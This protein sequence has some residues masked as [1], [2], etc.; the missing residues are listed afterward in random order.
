M[1]SRFLIGID[2]G[3]T[4]SVV[5][6]L[7]TQ[8][9]ATQSD[10][11]QSDAASAISVMDV[12][13]LIAHG[14]VRTLPAL[15]SFL[16]F[17]TPDELSSGAVSATWDE[18][19]PMVTGLLAREQGA[20]VPARQVSSAKSW[21]SHPGVNRRA[22]ILPAQAEP[23]QPMISP[24]EASARYLMHLRDAWNGALGTT[25][26]T[27]FEQQEIVLTVP[28]S[29]DEEA[30]ELTVEAARIAG[31]A[32]LTL[33]EEPLAAFYAWME[34]SGGPWK[35]SGGPFKPSVGLSGEG[36]IGSPAKPDVG[37]A[38]D[39]LRD[40]ELILICD[41]GG[42]T[43]DFSLIRATLVDGEPQF[44]RTA[45]GDHILLGGDNLDLALAHLVE[46]KLTDAKLT[47]R[48]R[49]AL[50][51][52]CCAAK[53][54]LLSDA[55][56][57][58][59]PVIILGSGRAVIG[60][61]LAVDLTREKVLQIL[62]TGFLPIT[63]PDAMPSRARPTALREL[64]L[65]YAAD[66]A[67]TR[68]LAAFLTQAAIAMNTGQRMVRP[69]AVLFNGGFCTPSFTRDRIATAI[70]NWFG[71]P[72][73]QWRPKLLDNDA[74]ESAVARGAACYGRVRR[75]TG[76]RVKV[77]SARAYYIGLPAEAADSAPQGIC[78]LPAGSEAGTTLPPLARE[79]T[80]LANR[81]VSFT[82]YSSRTRHDAH[83]GL[84]TL[85]EA[86]FHRHAPLTSLLRYGK[87]MRELYLKVRLRAGFTEVGTLE[88][89]CESPETGHRWRLQFELRGEDPEAQQSAQQASTHGAVTH[90]AFATSFA[91]D[92]AAQ[93]IRTVFASSAELDAPAPET[94][95]SQLEAALGAKR[96]HWP[97]AVVRGLADVLLE[98]APGRKHSPRHEL[99]WLN[100]LGF[101]LRPGF[102]FPGDDARIHQLWAVA[103]AAPVFAGDL[104]CQVEML[105]MLRRI[106]GGINASRQQALYREHT[107]AADSKKKKPR[108]N[109]QL[110]YE[111]WRLLASL[112]HL[113]ARH[114]A[115][116]GRELL[117]KIK[118]DPEDAIWLWSL[119]RLG[120][121]IPLYGPLPCVVTPEIAAEWLNVLLDLP[122]CTAAT[123]SAIAAI[124]QRTDDSSRDIDDAIRAQA[125]SRLTEFGIAQ[126]VI[127]TVSHYVPPQRADAAR[128]FG[129]SLP[130]GLQLV[131]SANCLLSLPA[132]HG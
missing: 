10:V 43:T 58:Q 35:P 18:D 63:P 96:D 117:T 13:Q 38:V 56:L 100:L 105:S 23:P 64:G 62:T 76:S 8:S 78:V 42:G 112:E 52:S 31:L 26:D 95:V 128:G 70:A 80:V 118:S 90:A 75:G 106:S 49:Y 119:S 79:F 27:R 89:W 109:R 20:L 53:E 98:S 81:P 129:E 28:A 54:K 91:F 12:P 22:K 116:L 61:A 127:A 46:E 55:S 131:S 77:G 72:Q 57:L 45:I 36:E 44:E 17:P 9:D 14:E 121:R 37:G 69:D 21:L 67:I 2:L 83:G 73:S 68:H 71:E 94:L 102:G 99:R 47:L 108:R 48:Q 126:E 65:P 3:T 92:S 125:I 82:L 104:Q 110:E 4:N 6:Y 84:A 19:P 40:G 85:D 25:P 97:V 51:L 60:Q 93:L 103:P 123:A 39:S 66:A 32:H 30:R 1:A 101:C 5:A 124:A 16:Y 29:F 11:T 41:I 33:L 7:D 114:R 122:T 50:R 86:D 15:P 74:V 115:A 130:Q 24:V 34:K 113:P 120:A 107:S 87:K 111:V 88:L 59:L 132:L